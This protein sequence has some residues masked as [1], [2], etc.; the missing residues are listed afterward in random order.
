MD[1]QETRVQV[2]RV[3]VWFLRDP[4]MGRGKSFVLH[5]VDILKIPE[6]RAEVADLRRFAR[7]HRH[8]R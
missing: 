7:K 3:L 6:V 1:F 5:G 4:G 2:A 8:D